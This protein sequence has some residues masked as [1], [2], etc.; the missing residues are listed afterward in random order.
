MT[1]SAESK[2]IHSIDQDAFDI[3]P[4]LGS[5]SDRGVKPCTPGSPTPTAPDQP[6]VRWNVYQKPRSVSM[7]F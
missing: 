1:L 2:A 5:R 4:L 3:G 6:T 7:K